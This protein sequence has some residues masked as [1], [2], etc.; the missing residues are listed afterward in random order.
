M[1]GMIDLRQSRKSC[2]T[3]YNVFDGVTANRRIGRMRGFQRKQFRCLL[4]LLQTTVEFIV[5]TYELGFVPQLFSKE[6][7]SEHKGNGISTRSP[8]CLSP[9]SLYPAYHRGDTGRQQ[10]FYRD[11]DRAINANTRYGQIRIHRGK[12]CTYVPAVEGG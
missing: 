8:L 3:K 5:Y 6:H 7:R 2:R 1:N 4:N 12:I 11:G 9:R 10:R